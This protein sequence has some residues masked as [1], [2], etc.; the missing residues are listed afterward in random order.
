M[1]FQDYL[2]EINVCI[3][4][5]VPELIEKYFNKTEKASNTTIL[6]DMTSNQV[7]VSTSFTEWFVDFATTDRNG[8]RG[9]W[10]VLAKDEKHNFF[11]DIPSLNAR[12]PTLKLPYKPL[13]LSAQV[14][15]TT[16]TGSSPCAPLRRLSFTSNRHVSFC[17]D[18]T[19]AGR[20][21]SFGLLTGPG[22]AVVKSWMPRKTRVGF[23]PCS[24]STSG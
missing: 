1:D 3:S 7:T 8:A 14:M 2:C 12:L 4:A 19:F 21:P 6:E 22:Y 23:C 20:W 18:S 5:P 11:S 17:M 16:A 13:D 9:S 10:S 24:C 15:P